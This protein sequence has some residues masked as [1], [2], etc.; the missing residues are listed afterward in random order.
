[1]SDHYTRDF[2]WLVIT[3]IASLGSIPYDKIKSY[4]ITGLY[5]AA[6]DDLAT[7]A[8]RLEAITKGFKVGL[9]YPASADH[10]YGDMVA[11]A[12]SDRL[13]KFTADPVTGKPASDAGQ[14]PV[15]L[16]FEP[17]YGSVNF[18][19]DFLWGNETNG[20]R[21]WRGSVGIDNAQ[22]YRPGRVSDMTPEPFK[23]A[24]LPVSSIRAARLD[25][26]VQDYFG[27]MSPVD[28]LEAGYDLIDKGFDRSEVRGFVDG[29]RKSKP[30]IF[31]QGQKV[32]NLQ[33]GTAIWNANL[34][35][36]SGL[37]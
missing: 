17:S 3:S 16:D 31:Y 4:G 37:I 20:T 7:S 1:L 18:W 22:G 34:M 11:K 27:D 19:L 10:Q 13:T 28:A 33:P 26:K 9:F 30:P 5:L 21:G 8:K 29:G 24:D 25:A 2:V 36:E 6:Q 23:G 15:L 14:T 32:R 35:R 12:A